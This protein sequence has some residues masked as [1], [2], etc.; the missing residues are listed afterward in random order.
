VIAPVIP[1]PPGDDA[2]REQQ[3]QPSYSSSQFQSVKNLR[4]TVLPVSTLV[5][6]PGIL[7]NA[8]RKTSREHTRPRVL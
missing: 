7:A 6:C 4:I 1:P 2:Q 3:N 8:R 5:V